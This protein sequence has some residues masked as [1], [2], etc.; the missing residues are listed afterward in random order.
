[1]KIS[2]GKSGRLAISAVAVDAAR[3]PVA[4]L[5]VYAPDGRLL[6]ART[7]DANR[8]IRALAV[9]DDD[10]VWVLCDSGG[11]PVAHYGPSGVDLG[12]VLSREALPGLPEGLEGDLRD[13][14]LERNEAIAW[15]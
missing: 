14:F 8:E 10:T 6:F 4:M 15:R 2:R 7:L 12:N 5:L 3:K 13:A 1:V 9:D 11:D